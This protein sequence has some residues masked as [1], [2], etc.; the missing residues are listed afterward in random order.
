MDAETMAGAWAV[1][2]YFAGM[3]L[4]IFALFGGYA[5]VQKVERRDDCQCRCCCP[6]G[7]KD[8]DEQEINDRI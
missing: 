6:D 1:L 5:L 3:A 2:M 8:D 7:C 4:V